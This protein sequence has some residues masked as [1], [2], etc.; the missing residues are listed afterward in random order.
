MILVDNSQWN[1]KIICFQFFFSKNSD[2]YSSLV[3]V[4]SS[5][6]IRKIYTAFTLP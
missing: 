2:N 6:A 3:V 1:V 5:L 4:V